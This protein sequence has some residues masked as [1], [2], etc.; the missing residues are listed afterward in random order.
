MLVKLNRTD[1][2]TPPPPAEAV[3][4]TRVATELI[5]YQDTGGSHL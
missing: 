4:E 5:Q 1:A 2:Q 3:T